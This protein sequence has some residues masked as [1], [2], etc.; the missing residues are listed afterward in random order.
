ME[1]R[2]NFDDKNIPHQIWVKKL[3]NNPKNLLKSGKTGID[4]L[5]SGK[6]N[7][8]LFGPETIQLYPQY[9]CQV[10]AGKKQ[11]R[12]LPNG[13]TMYFLGNQC[14]SIGIK[15]V[16]KFWQFGYMLQIANIFYIFFHCCDN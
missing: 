13:N 11:F 4:M 12:K 7:A 16:Q 5:S 2:N 9:P 14:G 6:T 1:A 3:K 10:I 8:I 15:N